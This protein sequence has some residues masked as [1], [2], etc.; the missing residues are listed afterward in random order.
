MNFIF[1]IK[2]FFVV[3]SLSL[4]LK[5]AGY[6]QYYSFDKIPKWVKTVEIPSS[7]SFSKYDILTGYYNTLLDYQVNLDENAT[8]NHQVLNVVSY[9]GITNASQISVALDTSYQKLKIHH[10]IIWR[11]GEKIDRTNELTFELMNNEDKLHE[12]IY[13]GQMIAYDIL[14]DIRKDDL[15]DFAYTIIGDNPI[16]SNE[17]YLFLS[18]ESMNPV[19]LISLKILY[20]KDKDY[21]YFCNGC[22]SLITNSVEGNY[23]VIDVQNKNV[24]PIKPEDNIPAWCMPYKYIVL[25][26]LKSWQDVNK[27]AQQVFSLEKDPDVS[28]VFK[29]IFKGNETTDD[30]INKIIN[31]VQDEI[32]YMGDESGLGSIKPRN[33]E[34]VVKQRYGDCKDK[35]LLLVWLLKKIGINEVYPAL[36]NTELKKHTDVLGTSNQIFNHC[37]VTFNYNNETF[38]I[39]P[40]IQMQGGDFRN[41]QILNY[42]KAL[43]IGKPSDSLQSI[44][45]KPGRSQTNIVEEFTISSFTKPANLK[46]ISTRYGFDADIR[47][48]YLEYYSTN[49]LVDDVMDELK[50]QFPTVTKL[51]EMQVD[52][53]MDSNKVV[54]T[55]NFELDGFWRDGDKEKNE[56][57]SG[58]WIFNFEPIMLY[59]YFVKTNCEDRKTDMALPYPTDMQYSIIFNFPKEL[60]IKDDYDSWDNAGFFFEIKKEQLSSKSF[61]IDYHFKAK[62]DMIK[63]SDFKKMCEQKNTI[64]KKLPMAI[65]FF[66]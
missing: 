55:Y 8:F 58:M 65:Y 47:R 11:K 66:K 2:K 17:K 41:V 9:S 48:N 45:L 64:T 32:R 19:D 49:K 46:T 15:I 20:S 51:G 10:L 31:F 29:E 61:K 43:V 24:K 5:S 18:L 44:V 57:T 33:P 13:S 7:S 12:G 35:S 62:S 16:F 34:Q 40:S 60:M 59:D 50:L 6:S 23:H 30:K 42:E 14:K 27:W 22:D 21:K 52:D 63:P 56:A 3:I 38:W 53:D 25:T 1:I 26:S 54:T 36:V 28:A 39:D 4:L 37:I